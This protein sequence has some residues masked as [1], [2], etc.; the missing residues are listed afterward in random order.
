MDKVIEKLKIKYPSYGF[1]VESRIYLKDIVK[2]LND[3]TE[4]DDFSCESLKSHM[5]PDGKFV[6]AVKDDEKHLI[7]IS[8]KKNQGT[9]D[10]RFLVRKN[11]LWVMLLKD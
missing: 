2:M 7:L 1:V 3:E 8:E 9:N 4:S 11:K 6:Y 10:V 5:S